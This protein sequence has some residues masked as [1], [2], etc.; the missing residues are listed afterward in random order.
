MHFCLVAANFPSS[1][2][3]LTMNTHT[4]VADMHQNMLKTREATGSQN[5][6][7]G[8]TYLLYTAAQILIVA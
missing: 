5:Q 8:D 3:E 7:V 4:I 6:V 1:Q 2:T